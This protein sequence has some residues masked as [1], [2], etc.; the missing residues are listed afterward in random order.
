MNIVVM[1]IAGAVAV[2]AVVVIVGIVAFAHTANKVVDRSRTEDLPKVL[3]TIGRTQS[4]LVGVMGRGIRQMRL[5]SGLPSPASTT[6][7]A[8]APAD[9]GATGALDGAPAGTAAAEGS[10]GAQGVI[11]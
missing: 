7:S 11:Q 2:L 9:Q 10:A 6:P 5:P 3:E 4:G 8:A 1:V